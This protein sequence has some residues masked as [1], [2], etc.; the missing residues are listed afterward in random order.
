MSYRPQVRFSAGELDPAIQEQTDL[1]KFR[2][3]LA[4]GRNAYIGKTGRII[5]RGGTQFAITPKNPA[6]PCV[7]YAPPFNQYIYEVNGTNLRLWIVIQ[8]AYASQDFAIPGL[9]GPGVPTSIDPTIVQFVPAGV[10]FVYLFIKGFVP[11]K[12]S[13]GTS[14]AAGFIASATEFFLPPPP[15]LNSIV[16][17]ASGSLQPVDYAVSFLYNG[18]E[19]D[20]L[21]ILTG[22]SSFLEPTGTGGETNSFVV[23]VP[24]S[25]R[26]GVNFVYYYRRPSAGNA[27]GFV[28]AVAIA[29]NSATAT[30]NDTNGPTVPD[31]THSPPSSVPIVYPQVAHSNPIANVTAK[32]GAIYQQRLLMSNDAS[33]EAV[34]GSR[35]GFQNDFFEESTLTSDS[36]IIFKAGTTGSANVLRIVDSLLGLL[37]FTSRGVYQNIGV[38]DFNNL[39]LNKKGTSVINEKMEPIDLPGGATIFV[40]KSTNSIRTLI[41]SFVEQM[42]PSE[43]I[44]LFSNHLFQ[45][46][47]VISWAFQDG[48]T[49]LVWMVMSDGTLISLTYQRE[50]QMQAWMRHD[51][52]DGLF[53]SVTVFRDAN[54][55]SIVYFSVNRGGQRSIETLPPKNYVQIQAQFQN[56][57]KYYVGMDAAVTFNQQ[58]GFTAL[59]GSNPIAGE[60]TVIP[61]VDDDWTQ[62]L[63]INSATKL[64]ANATNQGKVGDVFRVFNASGSAVDLTVVQFVNI[65][66]IV[67]APSVEYDSQYLNPTIY[68]TFQNLTG[69][70]QFNGMN[71][72]VLGDGYVI[73]SPN[74][75]DQNYPILTVVNGQVTLP[76]PYAFVQIG[77]PMTVDIQ[78]LDLDT[79]EQKPTKLE[80]KIIQKVWIKVYNSLAMYVGST[81]QDNDSVHGMVNPFTREE[82]P[83]TGNIG[84]A[85]QVP[86][87]KMYDFAIPNDWKSNGRIAIRQVD[88]LPLEIL[89]ITPDLTTLV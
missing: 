71:V 84:N 44:S 38:L 46:K 28:T 13:N 87:T 35:T 65:G 37:V 59:G 27:Y 8:G 79:V 53:E 68:L 39:A 36:A 26:A 81:L 54:N 42:F 12:F 20:Y 73:A 47:N 5:S 30:I 22:T 19:S 75:D 57:L 21:E 18:Q 77:I 32:T 72:S 23:N 69:L 61:T 40:D 3:G 17:G 83:D 82:D 51:T 67:V 43:E 2:T 70:N 86:Q 24:A 16:G 62:N 7:V 34:I 78:T 64:F 49:P 63:I 31:Y 85:A 50:S 52:Q 55:E 11:F 89:S 41:Y 56:D 29:L 76:R 9:G 1:D 66:Q 45:Y 80:S 14:Q 60:F 10:G 48:V 74:N 15:T 25:I 4:V 33:S 88:P 6:V 58:L